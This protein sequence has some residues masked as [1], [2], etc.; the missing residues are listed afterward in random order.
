[1]LQRACRLLPGVLGLLLLAAR[2]GE[3][4]AAYLA[5]VGEAREALARGDTASGLAALDRALRVHPEGA[6]AFM[7]LG[8]TYLRLGRYGEASSAFG[9]AADLLGAAAPEGVAALCARADA[10]ARQEKNLEAID[11]L[12]RALAAAPR[13]HTIHHDLGRIRL[14]L[15]QLQAAAGEFRKEIALHRAPG[16][17]PARAEPGSPLA[18]S[19]E[20]LGI[21]AYRMGDD[22]AALAALASAPETVEVLYHRGLALSRLGRH[23]EALEA[24]RGALAR[25]PD[26]RGALQNLARSA[27]ALGLQQE[28]RHALARF[29]DLYREEEQAKAVR[30][31]VRDLR[32]AAERKALSGDLDGATALLDEAAGLAPDDLDLLMDLARWQYRA[33]ERSRSERTLRRVL[34]REPLRAQAHYRL[35]RILAEQGDVEGAIASLERACQLAPMVLSYH[36]H[37]AQAY[38]R[39]GRAGEGVRELRLARRLEPDDPDGSFNLGVGL[40]QAGALREAAA[41]LERAVRQGYGRPQVHLV[42]SRVYEGLGRTERSRKERQIYEQMIAAKEAGP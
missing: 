10:L 5:F 16:G 12:Q 39:M 2:P 27:G 15:G 8:R 4:P 40:A 25:D 28:R 11:A 21:A 19:Y 31:R 22:E 38:L 17:S 26:H 14:A 29:G 3:P 42:L 24:F 6:D 41:E 35:G 7:L 32:K 33:G 30:V 20:G 36:V 9:R 23:E 18:S 1:M 34:E 37:L 13:R